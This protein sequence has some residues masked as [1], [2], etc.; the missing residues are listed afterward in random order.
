MSWRGAVFLDKDGTVL[1]NEPYNVDPARMELLPGAADGLRMIAQCGYRLVVVTNQSGVALGRFPED[2]LGSVATRLK[3]MFI[4][5]SSRL[6]AF[7]YCPHDPRGRIQTYA[8]QCDC[9]KPHPGLIWQA[10]RDLDIDV[11]SS[12]MIGD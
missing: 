4:A 7:Y 11:S 8:R 6:A 9:R 2:A 3:E 5:A 10:A 12:W 1:R